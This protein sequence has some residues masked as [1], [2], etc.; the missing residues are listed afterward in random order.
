MQVLPITAEGLIGTVPLLVAA[1]AAVLKNYRG[2]PMVPA[3]TVPAG[4]KYWSSIPA[5]A[6]TI[7]IAL[8]GTTP[9][10]FAE[11]EK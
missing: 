8:L 3:S 5:N 9:V 1:F 7:A 2:L 6:A 10:R 4:E 11:F